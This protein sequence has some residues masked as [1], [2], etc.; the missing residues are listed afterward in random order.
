MHSTPSIGE[1]TVSTL[2]QL[3]E[4]AKD[5]QNG[6][7][8]AANDCTDATLKQILMQFSRE[9][10]RFAV[11]LESFA[12]KQGQESEQT[13]SLSAAVHCGWINLRST[14]S[15]RD[16]LAVLEEWERGEDH[17][18]QQYLDALQTRQLGNAAAVVEKQLDQMQKAHQQIRNLRDKFKASSTAN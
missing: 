17:A 10:G 2:N 4:T 12:E 13:E 15:T 3:I 16:N 18:V 11:E 1:L 14:L 7:Q 9:R 8:A 6:F 5:G